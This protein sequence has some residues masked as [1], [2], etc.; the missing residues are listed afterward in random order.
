MWRTARPIVALFKAAQADPNGRQAALIKQIAD[1]GQTNPEPASLI[2][3]L[4][5][6]TLGMDDMI[7]TF[8]GIVAGNKD[9]VYH[10]DLLSPAEN[11]ALNGG[12]QRVAADPGAVAY[13]DVWHRSRGSFTT[14]LVTLHNEVDSLVPYFQARTLGQT[15][16]EAGNSAHLFQFTAP[17]KVSPLTGTGLSGY[18][19]CGFTTAQTERAWDAL[20]DWVQTGVRPADAT[21]PAP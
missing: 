13:V 5:T 7:K 19:H 16:A 17:P 20:H 15:V 12:I 10:S 9:R 2:V 18:A 6:V 3:P 14:P 8:G 4:L 1:L 21:L 11:A